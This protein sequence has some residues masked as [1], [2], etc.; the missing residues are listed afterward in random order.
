MEFFHQEY[1]SGLSLPLPGDL[2]HSGIKPTSFASPALA[3]GCFTTVPPGKPHICVCVYIYI[4]FLDSFLVLGYCEIIARK[5][6]Q[7]SLYSVW[8]CAQLKC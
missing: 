8:S 1:W 2:P 4:F 5:A 7:G 6:G 3:G